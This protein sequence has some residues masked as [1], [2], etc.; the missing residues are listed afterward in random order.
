MPSPLTE[1]IVRKDAQRLARYVLEPGEYLI[2]RDPSCRVFVDSPDVS[3][4]HARLLID[5]GGVQ[6]EDLG[7]SGGTWIGGE[8][9][10]S[11]R[12]LRLPQKVEVGSAVLEFNSLAVGNEAGSVSDAG[13]IAAVQAREQALRKPRNYRI[14]EVVAK[15]GMGAI[16]DAK[17]LNLDRTV[18]MKV[19]LTG[20][21]A[22][23]ES[24]Q[25]FIQ[26]ARVLA[27]LEH[28]NI[29]PVHELGVDAEGQAFY[30]MK[31]VKGVTLKR[32]L[33]EIKGAKTEAIAKY[34]LANLLTLLQKVCD[35]VA[36]AHSK[37]VIH[38]DLKPENIMLGDFGEVLV[39]DWG[40]AKILQSSAGVAPAQSDEVAAM[41][42]GIE[43]DVGG[44]EAEGRQDASPALNTPPSVSGS[45]AI[46]TLEGRIMGSPHFMSPEQAQGRISDIDER[47][48]IFALGGILYNILT[49]SPPV[50]GATVNEIFEKIRQGQITPPSTFNKTASKQARKDHSADPEVGAL[51]HCPGRRIPEALSAVTMKAL[52]LKPE[53]RYQTVAEFQ[54]DLAAY[55]GGF[56]T[57]AEGAG[58]LKQLTLLIK[59]NKREFS[60][61]AAALTALLAVAGGFMF[62][63]THTLSELR[64][65]APTFYGLARSL[66]EEQKFDEALQKI[67][68]AM[69]LA[70][71]SGDCHY[72]KGCILQALLRIEDARR[73]FEQ[74]VRRDPKN[75][76]AQQNLK[77]CEKLIQDNA[78]HLELS[79][80]SL[81]ELHQAMIQ[82]RRSA[83]A[84]AIVKRIG[85]GRELILQSW[86]A[87]L[88][89]A[90]FPVEGRLK[91][92]DQRMLDLDLAGL[93]IADVT[94]LRGMPLTKLNL[95]Y[96][97]ATLTDISPLKG[98][99]LRRLV[100]QDTKVSDLSPLKGMPLEYLDARSCPI[101][102]LSPLHQ[103]P[104]VDLSI[105]DN[106]TEL[107]D[108]TSL[109][110]LRL[111]N[112]DI[113]N[114]KV[115]DLNPLRGMPLGGINLAGTAVKD[116]SVLRTL[117]LGSIDLSNT[118][119]TDLSL[120]TGLQLS[121]LALRNTR[122]TDLTP[123]VGMPLDY[124]DLH[125][126]PA[127]NF[128]PLASLHLGRLNL[129]STKFS[130]LRVLEG[131]PLTLLW[132][133]G[134][135]NLQD[136]AP[137]RGFKKLE[138]LTIPSQVKDI[139]FLRQ[140]P[141]LKQ[142][143]F[144]EQ[145]L[146]VAEFWKAY[147]A[148]KRLEK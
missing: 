104:L 28:P 25:R 87:L 109:A 131:L 127:T 12:R 66:I 6:I 13:A 7:S 76:L 114:A 91:L 44:K 79:P 59:R 24:R 97:H 112:L 68:Y 83:E 108:L 106:N 80:E 70:P 58:T 130:D 120:L 48:D 50:I 42:S 123:L 54:R 40:L 73:D 110:G 57:S 116:F 93:P 34:P 1:T 96:N 69:T 5:D 26:E 14:G 62:K 38:R 100:I 99:Q 119:I 8:Q 32:V 142:L 4:K 95:G 89:K 39:M 65:T 135:K 15:G 53:Q 102:D 61:A 92:D 78:G 84:M 132:L 98:M 10:I 52:A 20:P 101:S 19:M 124:L 137:L 11:I 115:S 21:D 18:A 63:V 67:N 81:Q 33:E 45:D 77:L 9:V 51:P 145:T 56:A 31:F 90:G 141:S 23:P 72:L 147:D 2:G 36:F 138:M 46:Q 148:R 85:K 82:Q 139:E 17:D 75:E 3:R 134:C 125:G 16:R 129:S 113:A 94:P 41:L 122:I 55:Q 111:R 136:L 105:G 103:M 140:M 60:L 107:R 126:I 121:L 86:K 133:D 27:R 143:G 118:Q 49:L 47:A 30:T 29:V 37:G 117:P 71:G 64:G 128:T 74:A 144:S 35:A 22:S 43:A 88:T 146:P